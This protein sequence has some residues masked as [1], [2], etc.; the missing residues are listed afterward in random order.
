MLS[1]HQT[2]STDYEHELLLPVLAL[3]ILNFSPHIKFNCPRIRVKSC[4]TA[5][6]LPCP[7]VPHLQDLLLASAMANTN[8]IPWAQT[9][10]YLN[11]SRTQPQ[12]G[13][14]TAY[15]PPRRTGASPSDV[16]TFKA[17]HSRLTVDNMPEV[18]YMLWPT[19]EWKQHLLLYKPPQMVDPVTNQ[20]M[21][22]HAPRPGTKARPL[23][24]WP[25]L[26]GIDKVSKDNLMNFLSRC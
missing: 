19:I 17:G 23:L 5:D 21:F 12:P 16:T 10:D 9:P 2:Y 7:P 8:S 6:S 11:M 1:K 15:D 26:R 18:L 20:A 4:T 22:E 3:R 24:D 14:L 25:V 13:D